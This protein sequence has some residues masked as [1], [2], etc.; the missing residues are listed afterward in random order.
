MVRLETGRQLMALPASLFRLLFSGVLFCIMITLFDKFCFTEYDG[1]W[2]WL[3]K[4]SLTYPGTPPILC[5][6][7]LK[8]IE[9][10]G[11]F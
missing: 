3:D 6:D 1:G 5:Q 7:W 10:A 2:L 8:F 11:R 9:V 4:D